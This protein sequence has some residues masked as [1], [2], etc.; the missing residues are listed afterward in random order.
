MTDNELKELVA[1][2]VLS[3][4]ETDRLMKENERIF[5]DQA[6]ETGF[7]MKETDRLLKETIKK[8]IGK[9]G[10]SVVRLVG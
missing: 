3:Q 5:K 9:F 4:K 2:L 7:Q 10:K 1:S 6:K 8:L